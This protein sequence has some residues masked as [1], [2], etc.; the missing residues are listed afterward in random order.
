[1]A[2]AA[3]PRIA[4]LDVDYRGEG[5]V[6]ACVIAE[7]WEAAAPASEHIA[8]IANVA[9]YVPGRF[10]EREMPCLLAVLASL[11]RRPEVIVVDG[12][13]WLDELR[14]GLGARLH[15]AL[16][17]A[18]PVVGVAKTRYRGAPALEVC[19]GESRKPLFVT[20][21]GMPADE[22]ARQVGAMRGAHRV[23]SLIT[24]ADRLARTGG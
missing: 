5:A 20:A 23:P 8:H 11:P 3:L 10:F 24:R 7:G 18:V 1:M 13:V 17:G 9:P 14:P 15:E 6:A 2:L 21:I 16:G 12:Q 22:A 4:I 19:R